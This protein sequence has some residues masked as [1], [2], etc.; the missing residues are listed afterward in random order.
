[1]KVLHVNASD[2][3]STGRIV[4]DI[5]AEAYERGWKSVFLFPRHHRE[6]N[7][8]AVERAVSLP[9]EQGIYR[10]I[11]YL[12]GW[13]YGFAP[14]STA[15]ILGHIRK[16]KPDVVHLHCV[17]CASVNIYS[18]V[19]YLKKRSI[20]TVLTNHAEFFY[21]GNCPHAFDCDKWK[22]GCGK[23]PDV[24]GATDSKLIDRTHQ[25]WLKMKKVFSGHKNIHAVSVS[26][27]VHGRSSASPILNGVP[28]S[29]ILNGVNT[30][31]FHYSD[32]DL[33]REKL[34][35]DRENVIV[36]HVTA[37]FSDREN[38]LKSGRHLL[39]LAR[40]MKD[41]RFVVVGPHDQV[42]DLP[43]N[44]TLL[45]RIQDVRKIAQYYAAADLTVVVSKRETF[46][47]SVAESLCCG[48]PVVGF[49]AGGPES[50]ALDAYTQFVPFADIDALAW[51]V[52]EWVAY[53]RKNDPARIAEKAEAW[54]CSEKMAKSYCNLYEEMV[55]ERK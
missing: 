23:C 28:Q 52:Q 7:P 8:N 39:A 14:L 22:T 31:I 45:G 3:G 1:M 51:A 4:Q 27:W 47:M 16:E 46:G 55:K 50:V 17:N 30:D 2:I 54:Y 43:E 33:A 32:R 26:P 19:S 15:K 48:T 18:L 9:F 40:R 38:D 24:F 49:S 44:V 37:N 6:K 13:H 5:C 21:T 42:K 20:A 11:Y 34:G 41:V 53:K 36:L 12:T 29:V 25:A 10:R 35:L